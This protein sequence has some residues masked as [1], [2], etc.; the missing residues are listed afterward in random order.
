[1]SVRYV[2]TAVLPRYTMSGAHRPA[3]A[4][5]ARRPVAV[6]SQNVARQ[7]LRLVSESRGDDARV[8]G[9]D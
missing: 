2:L 5:V 9:H 8:M 7:Q 4:A 3:P 1:M 6:P